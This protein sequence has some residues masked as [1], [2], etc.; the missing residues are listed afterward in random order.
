MLL[1]ISLKSI[2]LLNMIQVCAYIFSSMMFVVKHCFMLEHLT[3]CDYLSRLFD[4][5]QK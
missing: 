1:M 5:K 4:V 3:Y 2:L